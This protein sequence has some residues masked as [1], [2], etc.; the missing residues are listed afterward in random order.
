MDGKTPEPTELYTHFESD[1][2]VAPR[3]I[4]K[5]RQT[6]TVIDPDFHGKRWLVFRGKIVDT[7]FLPICRSQIEV[8]IEGDW[9]K[10]VREM[11]G[12]H[13]VV[14]YGDFV[15]EVCYALKKVGIE[16]VRI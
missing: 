9:R 7:P 13:W 6:V 15:S 14:A 11:V 8:Q 2:G 1:Y 3:V 10:L 16:C 5:E 12:F 4:M